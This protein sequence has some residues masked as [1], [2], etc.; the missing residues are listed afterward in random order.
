MTGHDS[1]IYIR[2]RVTSRARTATARDATRGLRGRR[3]D[4][5]A[6]LGGRRPGVGAARIRGVGG[7][8]DGS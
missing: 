2:R 7:T 8:I 6:G 5:R 1:R 4:P 3:S